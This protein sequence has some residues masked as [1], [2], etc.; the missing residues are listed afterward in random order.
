MEYNIPCDVCLIALIV[1]PTVEL[2]QTLCPGAG[3]GATAISIQLTW[4]F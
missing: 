3:T 4:G 1:C 2:E